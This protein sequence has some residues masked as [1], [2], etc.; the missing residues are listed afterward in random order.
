MGTPLNVWKRANECA[1]HDFGTGSWVMLRQ[2]PLNINGHRVS[3]LKTYAVER[4]SQENTHG[5]G[6]GRPRG[7][8][9]TSAR[10]AWGVRGVIDASCR[11][12]SLWSEGKRVQT[13]EKA[14]NKPVVKPRCSTKGVETTRK[15]T[16]YGRIC[17]KTHLGV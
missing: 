10:W 8:I 13:S 16:S 1:R 7:E 4:A 5:G 6:K 11:Q 2:L 3:Q 12:E 9:D 17:K 15:E 14:R